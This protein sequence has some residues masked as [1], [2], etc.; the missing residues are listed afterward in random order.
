MNPRV[1][2][3]LLNWNGWKDT[4]ECLESIYRIKYDNSK[5]KLDV[6]NKDYT[7]QKSNIEIKLSTEDQTNLS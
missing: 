1:S 4:I 2:I 5:P 7:W 6:L 3:I